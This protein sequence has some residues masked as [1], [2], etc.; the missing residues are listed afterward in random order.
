MTEPSELRGGK[1][2]REAAVAALQAQLNRTQADVSRA[3]IKRSIKE[4]KLI[5]PSVP[6]PP[7]ANLEKAFDLIA[8]TRAYKSSLLARLA[9]SEARYELGVEALDFG[10]FVLVEDVKR[11]L[12]D[13]LHNAAT[14]DVRM[15]I[16]SVKR[17]LNVLV[18]LTS[19]HKK[20]R[21]EM[22]D[23]PVKVYDWPVGYCDGHWGT[24]HPLYTS[25][26]GGC[27]NFI[28]SSRLLEI[29]Q[30]FDAADEIAELK[31]KLSSAPTGLTEKSKEIFEHIDWWLALPDSARDLQGA[32]NLVAQLRD[33]FSAILESSSAPTP[34]MES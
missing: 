10:E 22:S 8:T 16:E 7:T 31:S 28:T 1:I 6:E 14:F 5:A 27:R 21:V 25:S 15:A 12:N 23:E 32:K 13:K 11:I 3:A 33:D 4:I 34:E 2:S 26:D 9:V 30:L 24:E 20:R 17:G 18:A 19:L 29:K